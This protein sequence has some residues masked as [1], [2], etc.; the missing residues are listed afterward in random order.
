M[1]Q[2]A[3]RRHEPDAALVVKVRARRRLSDHAKDKVRKADSDLADALL[4]AASAGWTMRELAEASGITLSGV[5]RRITEAEKWRDDEARRTDS[6]V[7]RPERRTTRGR[8]LR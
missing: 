7:E 4:E 2:T 6:G 1:R 5:F 3:K 8:N